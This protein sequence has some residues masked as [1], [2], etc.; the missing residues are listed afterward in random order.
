V[1]FFFQQHSQHLSHL[2]SAHIVL[3][4]KKTWC[5]NCLGFQTN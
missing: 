5:K 2:N 1:Q 4:P 3:I